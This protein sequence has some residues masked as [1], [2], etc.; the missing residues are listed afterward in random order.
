MA[1]DTPL[2]V[3]D[4][5]TWLTELTKENDFVAIV[6]FQGSWCKYDKHYL[7]K[8][9]RYN[10]EMMKGEGLKLIAWTS[11]GPE[12]AR[13]ADREWGLKEKFGFDDVIG[14]ETNALANYLIEDCILEKLVIKKPEELDVKYPIPDGLYPN[15]IVLP[16]MIWYAHYGT[17]VM[18]WESQGNEGHGF[19]TAVRPNPAGM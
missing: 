8:L 3:S 12:G 5:G 14:D 19:S 11:E 6:I 18:E 4:P 13:K 10:K 15:G 16:G 7:H 9:G 2:Y 17:M 1:S